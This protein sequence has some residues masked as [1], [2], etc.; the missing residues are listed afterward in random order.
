MGETYLIVIVQ[1]DETKLRMVVLP[2]LGVL[3]HECLELLQAFDSSCVSL[4]VP[5]YY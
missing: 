2:L 3:Y 5:H 4:I 1:L